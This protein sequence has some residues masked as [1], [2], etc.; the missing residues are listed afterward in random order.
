MKEGII[1]NK[2]KKN[3]KASEKNIRML[4]K[5]KEREKKGN[6]PSFKEGLYIFRL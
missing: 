4:R 3:S 2:E 5:S 1:L 6:I